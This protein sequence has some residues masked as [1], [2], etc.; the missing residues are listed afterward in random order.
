MPRPVPIKAFKFILLNAVVLTSCR[1]HN[2]SPTE[3]GELLAV[4]QSF[5]ICPAGGHWLIEENTLIRLGNGDSDALADFVRAIEKNSLSCPTEEDQPP[6][7]LA[8]AP[9]PQIAKMVV[10]RLQSGWKFLVNRTAGAPKLGQVLP[11]TQ[12]NRSLV[13]RLQKAAVG[14]SIANGRASQWLAPKETNA[15]AFSW[16][17]DPALT[18]QNAPQRLRDIFAFGRQTNKGR[19]MRTSDLEMGGGLYVAGDPISSSDYGRKLIMAPLQKNLQGKVAI[20]DS[21]GRDENFVQAW[22]SI[23]GDEKIPGIYYSFG[24]LPFASTGGNAIVIRND[25]V[26]DLSKVRILDLTNFFSRPWRELKA[27]KSLAPDQTEDIMKLYG[28]NQTI[29]ASLVDESLIFTGNADRPISTYGILLGIRSE[30]ATPSP[31][32]IQKMMAFKTDPT[33]PVT[34]ERLNFMAMNQRFNTDSYR[35]ND[36]FDRLFG[37]IMSETLGKRSDLFLP[38]PDISVA[39]AQKVLGAL[40]L[41]PS[42]AKYANFKELGEDLVATWSKDPDAYKNLSEGFGVAKSMKSYWETNSFS[43]WHQ[44]THE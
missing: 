8:L 29:F 17:N 35:I 21:T 4:G 41:L 1:T 6:A 11:D 28:S 39:E 14:S 44:F 19:A 12:N 30:L 37:R 27:A 43:A 20:F 15:W 7:D 25:G 40:G 23:V 42:N 26:M 10:S 9:N 13:Q 24:G 34:A 38:D 5:A 3:S 22:Q 31:T 33:T 32:I 16:I 2:I 36:F 18:T